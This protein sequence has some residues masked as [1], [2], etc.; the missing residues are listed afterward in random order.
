MHKILILFITLSL[1]GCTRTRFPQERPYLALANPT[2]NL[3]T[4]HV[5]PLA[6]K[7]SYLQKITATAK[8][9]KHT[10]SVYLNLNEQMLE[11]IAYTD[12]TGRL[13]KLKWTPEHIIWEGS[14]YIPSIIKPENII[15]DFLMIHLPAKEL[16]G[17]LRGA[18]VF[19]NSEGTGKT[20]IVKVN[21]VIRRIT[22]SKPLGKMWGHVIIENPVLGYK[23]AIQ[24][25]EQ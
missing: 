19:E 5:W 23:L 22:Y 4:A 6:F 1:I 13:Y 16:E 11:S 20:R 10:F 9:K 14:R 15:T 7:G 21:E 3:Q 2:V 18:R 24:T 8:G 12:M 17:L 25:V